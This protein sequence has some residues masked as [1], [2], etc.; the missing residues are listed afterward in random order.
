MKSK[1]WEE[2]AEKGRRKT[3]WVAMFS[4]LWRTQLIRGKKQMAAGWFWL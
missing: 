1:N 3:Y 2:Q 4:S